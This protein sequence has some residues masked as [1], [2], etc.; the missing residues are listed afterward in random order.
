MNDY[1]F[2]AFIVDESQ[3]AVWVDGA[4]TRRYVLLHLRI[5]FKATHKRQQDWKLLTKQFA[6]SEAHVS[7]NDVI[8]QD[9]GV[10]QMFANKT[11]NKTIIIFNIFCRT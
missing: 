7:V 1:L 9:V 4:S 8:N 6:L 3:F 11:E 2:G 5:I 10:S